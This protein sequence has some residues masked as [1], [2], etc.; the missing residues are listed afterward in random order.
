MKSRENKQYAKDNTE[1]RTGSADYTSANGE[2]AGRHGAPVRLEPSHRRRSGAWSLCL[3][4]TVP[5]PAAL[6]PAH[7]S[8]SSRPVWP[9][10]HSQPSAPPLSTGV[11]PLAPCS[12]SAERGKRQSQLQKPYG[13]S[14]AAWSAFSEPV[15]NR[16]AH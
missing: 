12:Q 7:C 4:S 10:L 1:K 13:T 15:G 2:R 16:T 6:Y 14:L 3:A 11:H 8:G 9:A 5:C